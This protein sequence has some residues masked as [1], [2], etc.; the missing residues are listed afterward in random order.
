MAKAREINSKKEAIDDRSEEI[1]FPF[2]AL[3]SS[4]GGL[5]A[6]EAFLKNVPEDPGMAFVIV[7]HLDPQHPSLLAEIVSK[8]TTMEV[9]Q[10]EN[11]MVVRRNI[12]YVMPPGKGMITIGGTLRLSEREYNNEPFMP[13]DSFLISLAEA[14]KENA[15]AVILSGNGSDGTFGLRS[16]HSKLG[17]IM[18][19]SPETAKYDGM[20]RSAI[21]TGLVDYVIPPSEMPS[22]IV[23]YVNSLKSG[24]RSRTVDTDKGLDDIHKILALVKDR[25]GHDFSLY[26]K[27]TINRRIER[28]AMVHQLKNKGQYATYLARNP[29]E[30]QLLFNELTIEVT[31]FFRN[32]KIFESLKEILRKEF[33]ETKEEKSVLRVWVTGCST[34]E[35]VYSIGIILKELVEETGKRKQIQIFGSDINEEAIIAA[36]MGVYP[37]AVAKDIDKKILERYFM[38]EETGFRVRKEIREMAIF[39]T[40]NVAQ[41][42]PFLHVDLLSCRNLLIYFEPVLQKRVLE[43]FSIALNPDGIL[44]LGE[45]ETIGDFEDRFVTIDSR[46]RLFKRLPYQSSRPAK[47]VNVR[48]SI[49]IG[50]V[51]EKKGLSESS[52]ISEAAENILLSEHTPPSLIINNNNEIIYFHGRTGRYLEHISGKATLSIQDMLR[53]DLRSAVIL[54]IEDSRRYNKIT[55]KEVL[56]TDPKKGESLLRIVVRPMEEFRPISGIMVIFEEVFVPKKMQRINRGTSKSAGKESKIDELEQELAYTKENLQ[57]TVE[58]LETSNEEL[59][60]INEELQSSNEELQS[61]AEESLTAKEE[62]N[63]LNE[64]LMAVNAELERKNQELML[65][66][67]DMRNLLNG[68]DVATIFLD[69]NLKIRRYTSQTAL[70][71]NLLPADIGRPIQDI[72][73]NLR[74]DDLLRDVRDVIETLNAKEKEIQTKEGLWYNLKINPYRTI[75]NVIDGVVITFTSIDS[76]KRTQEQLK[77]L[78]NKIE[79]ARDYADAIIGTMKEPLL[80]LDQDLIGQFA[81]SSFCQMFGI[82]K[83]EVKGRPLD[84][85]SNGALGSPKIIRELKKLKTKDTSLENL[86]LEIALPKSGKTAV[87]MTAR[88]LILATGESKL[89]LIS[90]QE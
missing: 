90:I 12:I 10:A 19:Q 69:N 15:I 73:M 68:V 48:T 46:G 7:T 32:P 37:I 49:S 27:S 88:R 42:P 28:R 9:V 72:A 40:H 44:F 34:G 74:Y 8:V 29:K 25:T 18:V 47:D 26:K 76:Q 55:A 20:P 54:A 35:E 14:W 85:I 4:A 30:I 33:F 41:D 23:K 84:E 53:K 67:G 43:T 45:S 52:M 22:L 56:L 71:M 82:K 31:S 2:V 11:D 77:D 36:R 64:E 13:I 80:V 66:S 50:R 16:I 17:M 60:S 65:T 70:L 78:S 89:I 5:E 57:H 1:S 87:K 83:D 51:Y 24:I 79:A 81:N 6:I 21:E 86:Q 75:E 58:R 61:V 3:G 62:L 59:T 39:A 63:S 38:K